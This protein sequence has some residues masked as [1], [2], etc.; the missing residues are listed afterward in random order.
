M[1]EGRVFPCI[2]FPPA[3]RLCHGTVIR[4]ARPSPSSIRRGADL[5]RRVRHLERRGA[6]VGDR[7]ARGTAE[8]DA[9]PGAAVDLK[10]HARARARVRRHEL[11][12]WLLPGTD[13]PLDL[14]LELEGSFA[15]FESWA[16]LTCHRLQRR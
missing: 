11:Y 7:A 8:A 6:L 4:A 13:L 1:T 14:H 2:V 3:G 16:S 10:K 9:V 5:R 12:E 15:V